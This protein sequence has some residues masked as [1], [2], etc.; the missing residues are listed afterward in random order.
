MKRNRT[1]LI[2]SLI[3]LVITSF[4]LVFTVYSWYTSN[5]VVSVS[6]IRGTVVD[7]QL[8]DSVEFYNFSAKSTSN[9]VTTLT[10][11]ES[12]K[13]GVDMRKYNELGDYPTEFLIKINLT[14]ETSLTRIS[15]TSN[16]T[17]FIGF[18]GE[19]STHP[20]YITST[21]NLSASS[22]IEFAYI[23]KNLLSFSTLNNVTTVQYYEQT[24]TDFTYDQI[25]GEIQRKQVEMISENV[26]TDTVYI[27]LNYNQDSL[28]DFYGNNIGNEILEQMEEKSQS[29]EATLSFK[30]D[31]KIMVV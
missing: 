16:A 9:G 15:I 22:I 3:S 29:E 13:N 23:P 2:F 27:M 11:H 21:A 8:I 6:T 1:N 14:Q 20:G 5:Q 31:F 28:A 7:N 12:G 24:Y 18:P 30:F 25:T 26:I 19:D 17:H 10:V 4:L